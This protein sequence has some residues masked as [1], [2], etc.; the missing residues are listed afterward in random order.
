MREIYIPNLFRYE[1]LME[2]NTGI[3]LSDIPYFIDFQFDNQKQFAS[4]IQYDISKVMENILLFDRV[5]VD[6]IVFPLIVYNLYKEDKKGTINL[7]KKGYL[8]FLNFGDLNISTF[9]NSEN[10][11]SIIALKGREVP[12]YTVK[13]LENYIF[14]YGKG[15]RDDLRRIMK[16]ILKKS[17]KVD[18]SINKYSKEIVDLIDYELKNGVYKDLGIGTNGNY[19][20]SDSNK[21]IFDAICQVVKSDTVASI[22]G[23]QNIYYSDSLLQISKARLDEYK[24]INES[25]NEVMEFEKIPDLCSLYLEGNLSVSDIVKLKSSRESK[26]FISWF[27]DNKDKDKDAIILDYYH[28]TKRQSKLDSIPVKAIRYITTEIAGLI[29]GV[30]TAV[31]AA[32]GFVD[33]FVLEEFKSKTPNMFFETIKTRV[34]K[35]DKI[36]KD[37]EEVAI[38]V[39]AKIEIDLTQQSKLDNEKAVSQQLH[40][41]SQN[42][43][44][45][46][47][48]EEALINYEKAKQ[49]F[50]ENSTQH[51]LDVFL[52]C[53]IN[54]SVIDRVNN[55]EL[56]E[57]ITMY[58]LFFQNKNEDEILETLKKSYMR[59]LINIISKVNFN[60]K[61]GENIKISIDTK[62]FYKYIYDLIIK[63]NESSDINTLNLAKKMVVIYIYLIGDSKHIKK[64]T[65]IKNICIDHNNQLNV[66]II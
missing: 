41:Y 65:D 31:G 26:A 33:S 51:T 5:Y 39:R 15:K 61:I 56:L 52:N 21:G 2:I 42:I 7:L 11:Y 30:G 6:S 36:E 37:I 19:S 54:I 66:E 18:I 13:D 27:V 63:Y 44:K 12:F 59:V 35:N 55:L 16:S 47:N 43:V 46:S 14:S 3:T 23:I 50:L 8:S 1:N 20:I 25:F 57:F 64:V 58:I 60:E 10:T 29:P 24:L 40:E 32:A 22:L 17:K 49:L 38:P 9:K 4:L 28:A 62:T 48:D 53:L 34:K 45:A